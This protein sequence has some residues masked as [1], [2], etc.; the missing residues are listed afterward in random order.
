MSTPIEQPI[1]SAL[2]KRRAP[3]AAI[4]ASYFSCSYALVSNC[5]GSGSAAYSASKNA[6]R[7]RS[8]TSRVLPTKG[9]DPLATQAGDERVEPVLQHEQLE[10]AAGAVQCGAG[11]ERA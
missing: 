4:V 3:S 7:S 5:H 2:A 1:S 10:V 9:L 6:G 8:L 11:R